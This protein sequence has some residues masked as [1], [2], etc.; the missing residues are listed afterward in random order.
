MKQ[1]DESKSA[2]PAASWVRP[3]LLRFDAGAAELGDISNAE[4]NGQFS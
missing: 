3:E 2:R 1:I 4:G